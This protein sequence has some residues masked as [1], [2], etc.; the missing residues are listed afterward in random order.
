M[1]KNTEGIERDRNTVYVDTRV[2]V[3]ANKINSTVLDTCLYPEDVIRKNHHIG[4]P[5]ALVEPESFGVPVVDESLLDFPPINITTK[6]ELWDSQIPA[7]YH[8]NSTRNGILNLACGKGKTVIAIHSIAFKNVKTLIVIDKMSIMV[9]WKRELVTHLN[10]SEK[11]IG[12]VQGDKWKWETHPV[13]I[14]SLSTLR[15]RA[16][17][18]TLPEGFCDSF[19]LIFYDECHHLS[20]PGFSKTCPLFIGE[21]HGLSATPKR[22][23]GLESVFISH[24]G[25]VYY[26]DIGQDL[27]PDTIIVRTEIQAEPTIESDLAELSDA[28]RARRDPST[29]ILDASGEIHHKKL[30]IWLGQHAGR[31][32]FVLG[33]IEKLLLAGHHVLALTH[34]REHAKELSVRM[35]AGLASG[36][37][38][39]EERIESI[40]RNK[41]SFA[42]IDVASEA[43]NVPSLSALVIMTPFGARE[44]GNILQQAYGRIQRKHAAKLLNPVVIIIEDHEIAMCRS[45]INQLKRKL[46]EWKYPL[47]LQG[48]TREARILRGIKSVTA[49]TV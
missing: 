34:S 18:G 42:T 45:L 37:V 39:P 47:S 5:R 13:V 44:Q 17:K 41:L 26:S 25:P 15:S 35:S 33:Q 43:L 23:D 12:W 9:Q 2:W 24:L 22:E 40:K 30:C 4:V 7:F 38:S 6:T 1:S 36:E 14:A 28:R 19:G 27:I 10:I 3:P 31:N 11:D 46:K 21:R 16:E 32:K 49:N 20:A 8:M 29:S 48:K